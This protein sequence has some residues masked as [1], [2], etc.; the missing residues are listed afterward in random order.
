MFDPLGSWRRSPLFLA[1]DML[2]LLPIGM[3]E[4]A[5]MVM[6]LPFARVEKQGW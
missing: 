3:E 1:A 5:V 4:E 6:V 2:L